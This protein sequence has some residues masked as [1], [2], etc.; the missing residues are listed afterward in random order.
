[1]R[2]RTKRAAVRQA[3]ALKRI[4]LAMLAL[5]RRTGG[6]GPEWR[7][8]LQESD[9]LAGPLPYSHWLQIFAHGV[10]AAQRRSV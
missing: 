1:M 5:Y 10:R 7:K 2:K 8:M 3:E 4:A 9:A 6:K